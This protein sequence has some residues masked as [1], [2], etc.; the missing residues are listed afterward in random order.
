MYKQ[1]APIPPRKFLLMQMLIT[2]VPF[3]FVI[4]PVELIFSAFSLIPLLPFIASNSE[5]FQD[6]SDSL[7]DVSPDEQQKIVAE[8]FK[9]LVAEKKELLPIL[10]LCVAMIAFFSAGLVEET[11]KWIVARRYKSLPDLTGYRITGSGILAAAATSALG[12]ATTEHVAFALSLASAKPVPMLTDEAVTVLFGTFLILI[13]GLVAYAVHV[14]TTLYIGVAVGNKLMFNDGMGMWAAF[15][16]AVAVHGLFDFI[17]LGASL[18]MFAGYLPN[19]AEWVV[20]LLDI[21]I[22]GVLSVVVWEKIKGLLER[23]N[24]LLGRPVEEV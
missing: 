21:I 3:I 7:D 23:E 20:T 14:G 11:A 1:L 4:I 22:A 12:F 8:F 18:L 10:L 24:V 19:W 5:S 2:A 9:R 16:V 15:G 13:R 17:G 6:L